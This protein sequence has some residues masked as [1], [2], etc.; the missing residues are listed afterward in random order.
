LVVL[1]SPQGARILK[2]VIYAHFDPKMV[3]TELV[4]NSN[5]S[6]KKE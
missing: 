4:K 5:G 3:S 2:F 6:N 1:A